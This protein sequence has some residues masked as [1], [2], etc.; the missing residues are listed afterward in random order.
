MK[1]R[2]F[3]TLLSG[4]AAAWPLAAR[5]Q[6]RERIGRV[7]VLNSETGTN[8]MWPAEIGAFREGLARSGWVEGRNLLIE[9]RHGAGDAARFRALA[10]ELVSLAP[11]VIVTTSGATTR[12]IQ[13]QTKT[14]PIVFTGSGDPVATGIVMNIARPEANTTGFV[15][16]H[17]S[18]GGKWVELLK[19][20]VPSLAR[21]GAIFNPDIAAGSYFPAIETA[22]AALGLQLS[23]IPVRTAVEIVRGIDGFAVEQNG[24]LIAVPPPV[25]PETIIEVA[26]QHRLPAIYVSRLEMADGGLMAYGSNPFDRFRG[27]AGY[28]DRLLRGAKANE[29]AVQFPTKFELVVNLKT[30]NAIGFTIPGALL[31]RA[32]EVIE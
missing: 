26:A 23:K 7:G 28:V 16:L 31:S 1:R 21:I 17:A 32:D 11:D 2:D 25:H 10:V 12:A 14:I 27:A 22:A 15:N 9:I 20:A 3:I 30:A 6:Q 19:E 5:A 18:I 4:A 24:G 29:L 13:G 8:A